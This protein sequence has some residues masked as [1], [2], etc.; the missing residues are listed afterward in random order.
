MATSATHTAMDTAKTAH[1]ATRQL[2]TSAIS[3]PSDVE[4]TMATEN[5][6]YTSEMPNDVRLGPKSSGR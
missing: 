2:E 3:L 5:A 6:P 1:M 4:I